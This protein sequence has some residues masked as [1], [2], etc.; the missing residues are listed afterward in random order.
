M[1]LTKEA[2]QKEN[3]S[4]QIEKTELETKNRTLHRDILQKESSISDL[5]SINAQ[6][7]AE[8]EIYKKKNNGGSADISKYIK[9]IEEAQ[10]AHKAIE[11][12]Y[13]NRIDEL[14]KEINDIKSEQTK[15][16]ESN[17]TSTKA[18]MGELALENEK[19]SKRIKE[20]ESKQK[21]KHDCQCEDLKRQ[22]A[23]LKGEK[24]SLMNDLA[25]NNVFYFNSSN[26]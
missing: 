7:K 19:L 21:S 3:E 15:K 8:N 1:K 17:F 10:L 6:L 26:S 23:E 20:L 24:E 9:Q 18:D 11:E 22:L 2:L 25:K 16:T 4:L 5:Q 14:S 13:K 12:K